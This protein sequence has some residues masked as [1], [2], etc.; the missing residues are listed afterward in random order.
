MLDKKE[1]FTILYLNEICPD[2]RPYLILA[3]D[4]ARFISNK[5]LI[6]TD[7]LDDIMIMLA[8]ENY[9]DFVVSDSKKGYY[10]CIT[11]KGKA[12]TLKKDIRRKR[13]EFWWLLGRTLGFAVISFV[14]GL[15]LKQ[16]FK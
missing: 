16:I 8:K 7:E 10:Y 6:T 5:Y 2:K 12:R 11:L 14:V 3:E 4:I 13:R 15:I 9:L 1:T